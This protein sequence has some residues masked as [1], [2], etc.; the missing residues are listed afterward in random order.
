[1][2]EPAGR[3]LVALGPRVAPEVVAHLPVEAA[4]RSLLSVARM[5]PDPEYAYLDPG[6]RPV[7][8]MATQRALSRQGPRSARRFAEGLLGPGGS[9]G[10][11]TSLDHLWEAQLCSPGTDMAPRATGEPDHGETEEERDSHRVAS[12][13]AR[14]RPEG[15]ALALALAPR[16]LAR[17]ALVYLVEDSGRDDVLP[18]FPHLCHA[19]PGSTEALD[20][21]EEIL[22][23]LLDGLREEVRARIMAR[24]AA[25]DSELADRLAD[26]RFTMREL[27]TLSDGMLSEVLAR[28]PVSD[29]DLALREAPEALRRR[30][31]R[32]MPRGSRRALLDELESG[33]PVRLRE[34]EAARRRIGQ[35]C[36]EMGEAGPGAPV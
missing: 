2:K 34:M 9:E 4:C 8:L 25:L 5:V 32:C 18:W 10:V 12:E 24:V 31:L 28:T 15:I 36:R 19:F 6:L 23:D 17:R 13:L 30:C 35:L 27:E 3:F 1:M 16:S 14:E 20:T 29:L 11:M 26:R 33:Q 7:A 22:G 21:G